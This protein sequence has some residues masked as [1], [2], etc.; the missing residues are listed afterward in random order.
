MMGRK[1]PM[2]RGGGGMQAPSPQQRMQAKMMFERMSP[3]QKRQFAAMRNAM[4]QKMGRRYVP[5]A[6]H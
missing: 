5:R 4:A 6:Q 3:A 1:K 2:R